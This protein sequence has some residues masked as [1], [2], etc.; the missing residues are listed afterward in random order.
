[1][2]QTPSCSSNSNSVASP[3]D[4]HSR[5]CPLNEHSYNF[6]SLDSQKRAAILRIFSTSFP[7]FGKDTSDRNATYGSIQLG[8]CFEIVATTVY[9]SILG[10]SKAST[11]TNQGIKK[12]KDGPSVVKESA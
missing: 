12:F 2:P 11:N 7:S 3:E 4:K 10:C 8:L 9:S 5:L 6:L 1:M